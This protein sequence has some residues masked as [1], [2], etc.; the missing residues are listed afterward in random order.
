MK[1]SQKNEDEHKEKKE[2]ST[3]GECTQSTTS[4]GSPGESLAGRVFTKCRNE[5]ISRVIDWGVDEATS[6]IPDGT[7]WAVGAAKDLPP[8]LSTVVLGACD[9][10][11][12]VVVSVVLMVLVLSHSADR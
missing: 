7:S 2:E 1:M 4:R 10:P 9:P 12:M 11:A 6:W 8:E 5:A 3:S